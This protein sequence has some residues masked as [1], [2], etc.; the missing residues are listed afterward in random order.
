MPW[1]LVNRSGQE[2]GMLYAFLTKEL[3]EKAEQAAEIKRQRATA[4]AKAKARKSGGR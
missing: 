2:I 4:S 1:D 3:D